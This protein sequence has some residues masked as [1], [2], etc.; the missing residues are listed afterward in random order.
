MLSRLP[1]YTEVLI[2]SGM[3][4]LLLEEIRKNAPQAQIIYHAADRLAT[5]GAHPMAQDVLTK[6]SDKID[7]VRLVA[8]DI[9]A[10]IP[11]E[12]PTLYLQH[13]I[14]K[15]LFD[16]AT[17]SPY[18]RPNNAI[19]VGDMLFDG[20]A[21]EAMALE[22]PDW[23]F[24]LFGAKASLSRPFE[25][26]VTHGER[27]FKEIAPFVRFADVGIAPY[28]GDRGADYISQSSIKMIQ[29]SY[30]RLPMVAPQFAAAG[31]DHVSSYDPGDQAS[32]RAAF[33]RA[34]SYDRSLIVPSSVLS[35]DEVVE[36]L[37]T[38]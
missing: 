7:L 37:F 31:R 30:C 22:N 29:Y 5:I 33:K 12:R 21:V 20:Q 23:T 13:G 14:E 34:I 19:S 17:V 38:N 9:R 15:A 11:P 27:P 10:D 28:A 3:A 2:E 1:Y 18:D 6:Q 26:V 32:I 16:D 4:L 36:R 25:N 35:W 24:H 8:E